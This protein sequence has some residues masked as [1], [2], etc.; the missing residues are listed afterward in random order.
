MSSNI[1]AEEDR[2][3]VAGM[4][5]SLAVSQADHEM[6][7]QGDQ[8]TQAERSDLL[9]QEGIRGPVAAEHFIGYQRCRYLFRL[10]L[11]PR[12]PVHEGLGLGKKVG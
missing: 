8:L 2:Y 3:T 7:V 11:L 5:R 12:L 1:V 6:L 4:I 9:H 10:Q